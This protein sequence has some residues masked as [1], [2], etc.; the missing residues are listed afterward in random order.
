MLTLAD[1]TELNL[2]VV[3]DHFIIA[4]LDGETASCIGATSTN[5]VNELHGVTNGF[6]LVN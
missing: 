4:K 6:Q 3:A 2:S 1:V 5:K